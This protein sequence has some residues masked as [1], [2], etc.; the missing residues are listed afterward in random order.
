MPKR[1][2]AL[3]LFGI[4][5][6]INVFFGVFV[7]AST[8]D[9]YKLILRVSSDQNKIF[10][11]FYGVNQNFIEENS[12]SNE[13]VN[14]NQEQNLVFNLPNSAKYLRIDFGN[15]PSKIN[16]Y[17]VD[18]RYKRKNIPIQ[19]NKIL[20]S[21]LKSDITDININDGNLQIVTDKNDPFIVF[22]ISDI[23][24]NAII[25]NYESK[26]LLIKKIVM[27]TCI[28]LLFLFLFFNTERFLKIPL[29]LY[30]SRKLI[31]YLAKND[32]KTKY[33]GSYFGIF[34]A[35]VQPVITIALY[36]FVFQVG[37][38]SNSMD[39]A[40]FVLWLIAGLVPWFYYSDVLSSTTN[41]LL[42]YSYLVKKVVFNISVLPMVK[43]ISALFVHIFFIGF[44]IIVYSLN[45][46]IPTIYSIQLIYYTLCILMI[47]LSLSY[48]TCSVTLFFRD[49]GQIINIY[50]QIA[51]WMTPIMWNNAMIPNKYIWLFKLNPMYYIVEGYRDSLINKVWFFEKI[52]YTMYFWGITI[53]VFL[54]GITIFNKLKPHFADVI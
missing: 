4:T 30:R 31:F 14:T 43:I 39:D 2:I 35:F 9:T 48:I 5:V 25:Y 15:I 8:Q 28:D 34:W 16:I 24:I 18:L 47:V 38:R 27:C 6:L 40:P 22:S 46:F 51:M 21:D 54:A 37:F 10:Q 36:W 41:C 11:V 12:I 23:N 1:K 49:L 52:D 3:F 53:F 44:T 50:L 42:E 17:S 19:L 13:Y 32:F 29:N 26:I 7:H 33:A 20:N 45:G